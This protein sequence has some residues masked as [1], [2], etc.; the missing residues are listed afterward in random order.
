MLSSGAF[1][2]A[3][4][5]G[6]YGTNFY[7]R[8]FHATTPC[9]GLVFVHSAAEHCGR[10][11]DFHRQL[12]AEHNIVVFAFDLRGFGQTALHPTHRSATSA[13]GKTD[14]DKQLD[15]VEW[16]LKRALDEFPGLPVFLMGAGMGGGIVLG[17]LCDVERAKI[18]VVASLAGVIASAPCITPTT[19]PP[20]P[21]FWFGSV[22]ARIAPSVLYPA[23]LKPQELSHNDQ[24][25]AA[26]VVDPFVMAPGSFRSLSDMLSAGERI[27]QE[28]HAHWPENMPVLF[29]HGDADPVNSVKSTT[30][31]CEKIAA[32]DKRLIT[33][34]S[35]YHE[36]HNEPDGVKEKYLLDVVDF[37]RSHLQSKPVEG[38]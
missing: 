26:Y 3:W 14:W 2:D 27:L 28:D 8:T 13:Y 33:Y 15:D 31:L 19:P 10:Y 5:P 16:A 37:V 6:P 1:T 36:L 38:Q 30:A 24:T 25:N 35:A 34:P 22:I 12:A 9:A 11:T 7:T 21:V 29:L 17:L 23:R 4:V 20:R 18:P 32:R